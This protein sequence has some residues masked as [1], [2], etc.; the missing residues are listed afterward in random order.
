M[1][2]SW[3]RND[4]WTQ[5][6]KNLSEDHKQLLRAIENYK[7]RTGSGVVAATILSDWERGQ[8]LKYNEKDFQY[9]I[10]NGLT[11]QYWDD[12]GDEFCRKRYIQLQTEKEKSNSWW[13][14]LK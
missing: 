13:N 5:R 6:Y 10:N 3:Q 12:K 8:I 4:V 9:S 7:V 1:E 14:S 11:P 2:Y